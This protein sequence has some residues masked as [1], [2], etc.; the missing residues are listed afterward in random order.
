MALSRSSARIVALIVVI[1][2]VASIALASVVSFYASGAPDGL[3]RVAEDAGFA[4]SAEGSAADGSPLAGYA[5]GA[6]ESRFSVGVAG[7]LGVGITALVAFG[8]FAWLRPRDDTQT[9]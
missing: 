1:G 4:A 7:L 3:E 6:D 2:M 9:R 8:L 5:V